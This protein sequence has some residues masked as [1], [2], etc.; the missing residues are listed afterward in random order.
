MR[1]SGEGIYEAVVQEE[2]SW[3]AVAGPPSRLLSTHAVSWSSSDASDVLTKA[4]LEG[5]R[6]NHGHR[7][8]LPMN[9]RV[10]RP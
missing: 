4:L 1:D 3:P 9:E 2:V 5:P 6:A 7:D 10:C 8:A